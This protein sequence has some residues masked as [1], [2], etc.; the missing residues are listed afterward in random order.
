MYAAATIAACVDPVR[1]K[2]VEN[3]IGTMVAPRAVQNY[4]TDKYKYH[5]IFLFLN[6]PFFKLI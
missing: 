1:S 4:N 5:V 3:D 2:T 6:Y